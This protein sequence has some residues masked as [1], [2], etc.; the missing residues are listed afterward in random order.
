MIN[1]EYDLMVDKE[2][3]FLKNWAVRY[4]KNK[5]ILLKKIVSVDEQDD[6]FTVKR[7]E[8]EQ[9][10]F[11]KPYLSEIDAI[12]K[13]IKQHAE[14]K[15]LICFHTKGNFDIL[16]KRWKDFVEIG[17]KFT[18]YF[19]NP[20]SKTERVL[21]LSPYT[22]QMIADDATLVQGLKTMA[23]NVEFTTEDEIKKIINS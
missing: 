5:D 22:H 2:T 20:F 1:P 4:I 17:R 13:E 12:L 18:I 6:E 14:N 21:N 16:I 8:Q 9:R 7:K 11:V 19:V 10:F 15:A 3:T 23:E